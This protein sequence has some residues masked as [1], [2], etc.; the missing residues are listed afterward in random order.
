MGPSGQPLEKQGVR[1]TEPSSL[2]GV[3]ETMP[4]PCPD[5]GRRNEQRQRWL[6]VWGQSLFALC[7][8]EECEPASPCSVGEVRHMAGIPGT[9]GAEPLRVR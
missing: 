3:L 2:L 4:K 5:R 6:Q 7:P 1:A 8:Q 9:G